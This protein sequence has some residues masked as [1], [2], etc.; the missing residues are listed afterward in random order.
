MALIWLG[1][2]NKILFKNHKE[3]LKSILLSNKNFTPANYLKGEKKIYPIIF[4]LYFCFFQL[5][6]LINIHL[7]EQ[8]T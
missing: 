3:K 7:M 2:Q 8:I 4:I 6:R 1:S 5:I